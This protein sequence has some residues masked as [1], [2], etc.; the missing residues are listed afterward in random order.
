[1][2]TAAA[3]ASLANRVN[4][5]FL[6]PLEK[7]RVE[8]AR[9]MIATACGS[10]MRCPAWAAATIGGVSDGRLLQVNVS[11]GGVPKR[12]VDAARIGRSA[13][14]ATGRQAATVHGGP[15]RAVSILGVEAIRRIAA[16]GHPIAPGTTG[17][18]L[19]TEGFDVSTLPVGTRLEIGDEVVL[20]LSGPA[21]PCRTIRHSFATCGSG[22]SRQAHPADSRMYARV[23]REGT[24]RPGDPIRLE[25]P[26][27]DAAGA[28]SLAV[29][30][31][32]RESAP[33]LLA[34]WRVA[35]RP[36]RGRRWWTTAR[37]RSG[38][39]ATLPGPDLQPGARLRAPAEPARPRARPL[40]GASGRPA[41]S[42]RADPPWPGAIVDSTR[43][44]YAGPMEA[45]EIDTVAIEGVDGSRAAARRG[46]CPGLDVIVA[47]GELDESVADGVAGAGGRSSRSARTTI[48]SW[49][50]S[51]ARR[52][53][54]A[55]LHTPPPGRVAPRRNRPRRPSRP[56]HP[57]RAHRDA[58]SQRARPGLRTW[59]GRRPSVGGA[60]PQ[61]RAPR[62]ADASASAAQLPGRA[63]RLSHA[64]MPRRAPAG[65][66]GAD[67][68][69]TGSS[70]PAWPPR[71]RSTPRS[72][73]GRPA[74]AVLASQSARAGWR[75]RRG[76]PRPT[77]AAAGPRLG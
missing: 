7:G 67:D 61:P 16:E 69:S 8:R 27:G 33:R 4:I 13:W 46:R 19:T 62:L 24:V 75:A 31:D 30:L 70:A 40:R 34:L 18:N 14:R 32:E 59:S 49:P 15:H 26:T 6:W 1:M 42:G 28:T 25:A 76:A 66:G 9:A 21:N 22:G 57:A 3:T 74:D 29:R 35:A 63:G 52:L 73:A 12:P 45:E 38:R 72:R 77:P 53:A 11:A 64:A 41:G 10:A 71:C 17:E 36:G 65:R 37:S 2:A 48:D 5:G 50:R 20:E 60:R 68:G 56:R 44:A 43:A 23:L 51:T 39:S 54:P 55:S 58:R 47:A